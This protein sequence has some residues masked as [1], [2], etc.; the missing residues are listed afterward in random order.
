MKVLEAKYDTYSYWLQ[1][2]LYLPDL[3]AGVKTKY[4]QKSNEADSLMDDLRNRT[5]T[6]YSLST[7]TAPPVVPEQGRSKARPELKCEQ[8]SI[9][10]SPSQLTTWMRTFTAYFNASRFTL[11]TVLEQQTILL[12]MLDPELRDHIEP[13]IHKLS[14]DTA[15]LPI[16]GNTN[17]CMAVINTHWEQKYPLLTRQLELFRM[18]QK[19]GELF[20]DFMARL[21]KA[22]SSAATSRL[23]TE[24]IFIL[25][26]LRGC[27][28]TKLL[29][30]L[31]D[32]SPPPTDRAVIE[33]KALEIERQ[34]QNTKC[35]IPG[36]SEIN[37][38]KSDYRKKKEAAMAPSTNKDNRP[39]RKPLP[40]E[41]VGKCLG[42]ASSQHKTNE[43]KVRNDQ[44]CQGCKIT[45]HN[46]QCCMKQ[47]LAREEA[48][49]KTGATVRQVTSN[50]DT[51]VNAV[52][53]S[54][55]TLS[56]MD[57]NP[58]LFEATF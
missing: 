30:K 32:I 36:S 46:D 48:A 18:E 2:I 40:A 22:E 29:E 14:T 54:V 24:T 33:A 20:S 43:C 37:A 3:E 1:S 56:V 27:N 23:D 42:C 44:Y 4:Q 21:Q 19:P 49:K 39:K 55:S 16:F 34:R 10:Y 25:L 50:D 11:D 35:I 12:N 41:L 28:D 45:R 51:T 8:L 57:T 31:L 15:P 5:M 52:T 38:V 26:S 9:S 53:T 58:S 6:C 47:A 13:K 7:K 17:S